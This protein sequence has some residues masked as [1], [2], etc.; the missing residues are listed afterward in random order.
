VDQARSAAFI[1][2]DEIDK[3]FARKSENPSITRDVSGEGVTA[4]PAEGCLEGN[5]PPTLP[6]QG[7]PQASLPDCIQIDTARSC[8][9]PV[10]VLFVV[11][12]MWCSAAGPQFESLPA[13][14]GVARHRNQKEQ[15]A[16]HV[17]RHRSPERPGS[18]TA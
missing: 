13:Q 8:F 16:A 10:V 11:S 1:Y 12:T 3:I 7:G 6:P 17:L 9:H 18:P 5:R 2:I 4:G 14:R 15:Q